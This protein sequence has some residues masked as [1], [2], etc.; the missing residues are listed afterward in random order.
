[1]IFSIPL[2]RSIDADLAADVEKQAVY[3]ASRLKRLQVTEDRID[4]EIDDDA[5]EDEVRPKIERYVAAMLERYRKVHG[6][7]TAVM[8]RV[9]RGPMEDAVFQKLVARG[10]AHQ[11]GLGLVG[12]AGPALALATHLD[13]CWRRLAEEEFGATERSYPALID[14]GVLARCGYY[15]AFP[16][17]VSFVAH[18][19]E[20]FDA[21]EAFREANA[22]ASELRVPDAAAFSL[23]KACAK[24]ATCY[25][26]YQELQ[27]SRVAPPGQALTAVGRCFRY[28][29]KN[30]VGLERL[31]DFTMREVICVGEEAW[32]SSRRRRM[33]ARVEEQI[34]AWDIDCV[35]ESANDPFFASLYASKAFWQRCGDLKY[36]MKVAVEPGPGG[37][38]RRI[39]AGSF[40]LHE[41]H[42]GRAFD[43][44][45]ADRPIFSG[46][47]AWGI[48]RWVL[49]FFS[50][51]GFEPGRWP[52][53]VR[54]HV[55]G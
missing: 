20:D 2:S 49:A 36:E 18:L 8:P 21:I 1:M 34:R 50:Q 17:A 9:D 4:V 6:R 31:W 22:D 32:V 15:T 51:H 41:D 27:G 13:E 3:S 52:A 11:L 26:C 10:W 43:I 46:C 42:F 55:F 45:C 33:M 12:L 29:S 37:R 54:P 39:A 25:H 14:A 38:A 53:A 48:E 19:S 44:T 30:T 7:V 24:P 35:F 28:E 47:T 23:P 16:H 40:N 5:Q